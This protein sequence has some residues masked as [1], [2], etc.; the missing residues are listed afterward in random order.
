CKERELENIIFRLQKNEPI[1]YIR[2]VTEFAGRRFKVAPG[3]L[4]P[5]PETAE[6][7]ALVAREN[8]DA[9]RL[10]DIGTGSGCIA[11][12]LDKRLPKAAVEA[13]DISE[14]A[15]TIART[16]NKELEAEVTFLKRDVFS[17]DWEKTPSFDVIVS[18]PPY[19]TEAEKNEMEANVLDW[20]PELALFVPDDDPLRF[21]LRIAELGRALLLPGGRLYFEINQAYGRETAHM[22]E[23]NQYRDVRV[24]KDIFG[25]DRIVTANR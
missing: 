16:N 18:N 12:S 1:Q 23:M 22:L 7:V 10:L 5:R 13:W 11:I 21:Y 24:V 19:V 14:T 3:V 8:T 2:G 4:I 15:L 6:L 17:D 9:C 25:K 20:E